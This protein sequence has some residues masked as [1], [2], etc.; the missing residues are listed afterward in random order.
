MNVHTN[1][2]AKLALNTSPGQRNTAESLWELREL[3]SLHCIKKN[4]QLLLYLHVLSIQISI[5]IDIPT[6]E[7]GT[8]IVDSM[9]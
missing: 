6:Q 8:S 7:H 2:K 4:L 5:S 9:Q 1:T 3:Q